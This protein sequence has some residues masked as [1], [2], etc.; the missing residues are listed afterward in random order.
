MD[1]ERASLDGAPIIYLHAKASVFNNELAVVSSANLNG[2]SM[3]WDTEAGLAFR[4][5]EEGSMFRE[6]L[7]Q[8]VLD[9]SLQ[10]A[11]WLGAA[12]AAGCLHR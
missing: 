2:R 6:V 5:P 3:R 7:Q 10:R 11:E 9:S 8:S 1:A 12:D 4:K